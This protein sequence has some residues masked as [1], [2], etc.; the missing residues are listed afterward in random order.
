[1]S[2]SWSGFTDWGSGLA[3]TNRYK[4]VFSTG[5]TP[6]TSCTSGTQRLLGT[7]TSYTHTG[8]INGT[9]YYYRVCASDAA[10]NMSTGATASA[11]P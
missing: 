3:S 4:L 8:L 11:R 2:L 6:A 1:V 5:G 10:G 7:A 9:T